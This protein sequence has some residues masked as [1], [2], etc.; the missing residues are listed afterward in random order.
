MKILQFFFGPKNWAERSELAP[1]RIEEALPAESATWLRE[2][3]LKLAGLD[4]PPELVFGMRF[5]WRRDDYT[6]P[7]T[8]DRGPPTFVLVKLEIGG[9]GEIIGSFDFEELEKNPGIRYFERKVEEFLRK[10]NFLDP[11]FEAIKGRLE[12]DAETIAVNVFHGDDNYRKISRLAMKMI[13]AGFVGISFNKH[14]IHFDL[15]KI[16]GDPCGFKLTA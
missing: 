14:G 11:L 4:C 6:G 2:F 9:P 8:V 3:L 15:V 5:L 7:I 13:E 12:P 10:K 16:S 1:E